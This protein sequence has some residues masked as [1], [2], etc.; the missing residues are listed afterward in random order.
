MQ[1]GG[2]RWMR[3]ES[4]AGGVELIMDHPSSS[5][6]SKKSGSKKTYQKPDFRFEKVF[7]VSA[8]SCGKL[9]VTQAQCRLT[10]TKAS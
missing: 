7:E 5:E 9:S 3:G 6:L 2:K 1:F 4:H 10:S 8:L